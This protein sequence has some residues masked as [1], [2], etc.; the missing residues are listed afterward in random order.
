[1]V[2]ATH[3]QIMFV[4]DVLPLDGGEWR[5]TVYNGGVAKK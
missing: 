2:I 5:G 3:H 4:G 1:M